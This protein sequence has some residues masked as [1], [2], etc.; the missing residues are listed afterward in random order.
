MHAT[1]TG[2]LLTRN[3]LPDGSTRVTNFEGCLYVPS[4]GT[5]LL[6]V[7]KCFAKAKGTKV[8]SRAGEQYL[9]A[10][11]NLMGYIPE[12]VHKPY[13]FPLVYTI[14]SKDARIQSEIQDIANVDDF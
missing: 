11:N 12:P 9:D 4:F 5:D 2:T 3:M 14:F 8:L 7:K 6:S 13:L 1:G 10:D